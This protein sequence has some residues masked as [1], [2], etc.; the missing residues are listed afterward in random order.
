MYT[1]AATPA[2]S[3]SNSAAI[4][5]QQRDQV[6]WARGV[7]MSIEHTRVAGIQH[8]C[9][10]RGKVCHSGPCQHH[11]L[12]LIYGSLLKKGTRGVGGW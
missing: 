2:A 3:S 12:I 1:L 7:C 6:G 5:Y 4:S 9:L 8:V 11:V 10:W